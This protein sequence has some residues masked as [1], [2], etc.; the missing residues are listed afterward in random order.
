MASTKNNVV[1]RICRFNA[2]RDP[3]RLALKYQKMRASPFAFLRGT[4]HLFYEELPQSGLLKKAPLVWVC[5]DLQKRK[6]GAD[7]SDLSMLCGI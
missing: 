4:C 6:R 5:G 7:I 3:Q 2:G 1:E